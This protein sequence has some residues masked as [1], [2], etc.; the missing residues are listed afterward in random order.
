M[1]IYHITFC[2]LFILLFGCKKPYA[3]PVVSSPNSFIVVEGEINPGNDSTII[4]LSKTVKL[5]DKITDNPVL[6]ARVSVENDQNNSWPLVDLES[7]GNYSI[8][9]LNLPASQKYRLKI[10]TADN[11]QYA[12]DFMEVKPA[13]PIDSI[14]YNIVNGGVQIYVNAHDQANATRFYRWAYNETWKFQTYYESHYVLDT[15]HQSIVPRRPDQQVQFCFGNAASSHIVLNSTEKLA[16]DVVYQS[17]IIF[18]PLGSE[19][20]EFKYSILV[21]QYALTKEAFSFYQNLEKSTE[22]LG[23]IFDAQP[24]QLKGNIHNTNDPNEQVIGYVTVSAVQSKRV[25]ITKQEL[26][27]KSIYPDYPYQCLQDTALYVNKNGK[28][29]YSLLIKPPVSHIPTYPIIAP[30]GTIVGYAYT[31]PECADCTL[32]GTVKT[33]SFWQE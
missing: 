32:R 19:K 7:N 9:S 8:A 15:V 18:I 23:G 1:A 26:G 21:K 12:S 22:Q 24:S 28:D 20:F 5:S 30:D 25:F 13:P 10:Q 14:G 4:K 17:P 27:I 31:S 2:V 29:V 3:P 6:G 11:K 33:P 16:S